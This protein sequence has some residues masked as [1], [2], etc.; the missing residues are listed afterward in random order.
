[1]SAYSEICP[2]DD[3]YGLKSR[4]YLQAQSRSVCY[5]KSLSL[6]RMLGVSLRDRIRN[7]MILQ[8]ATVIYI[9]H[10]ITTNCRRRVPEKKPRIG[11]RS[12]GC[13]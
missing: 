12:V 10:G 5:T 3:C 4:G 1:M 6:P 2:K 8:T 13:T 9:A 7:E 11:I